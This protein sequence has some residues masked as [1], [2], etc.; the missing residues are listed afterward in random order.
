MTPNAAISGL[1]LIASV[2]GTYAA[3]PGLVER[4]FGIRTTT[5]YTSGGAFQMCREREYDKYFR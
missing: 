3:E 2:Q 4:P 1:L 5:A